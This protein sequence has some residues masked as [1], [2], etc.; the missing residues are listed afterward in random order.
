MLVIAG[1]ALIALA[2]LLWN[3]PWK[4]PYHTG[5]WVPPG[6]GYGRYGAESQKSFD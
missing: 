6:N 5:E 3:E 1:M 4:N 2:I